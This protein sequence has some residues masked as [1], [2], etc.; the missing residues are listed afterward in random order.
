MADHARDAR[1][2]AFVV[3]YGQGVRGTKPKGRLRVKQT[4]DKVIVDTGVLRIVIP[5]RTGQVIESVSLDANRD[6]KFDASEQ[7]A[8]GGAQGGP[9]L[10]DDTGKRYTALLDTAPEVTVEE[11]GPV[12]A[13]VRIESWYVAPKDKGGQRLCK[14]I[15]RLR[16]YQGLARVDLSHGWLMTARTAEV[17]FSDIGFSL[18]VP[19]ARH[20]VLAGDPDRELYR[21]TI[22]ADRL[23][24]LLQDRWNHFGVHIN[25]N[26]YTFADPKRRSLKRI[27]MADE[28]YKSEGWGALRSPRGVVAV[29]CEDFW[30]NYPKEISA[31]ASRLTFHVWPG[32]GVDHEREPRHDEVIN[33]YWLHESR[34]LNFLIAPEVSCL[35]VQNWHTSKYFMHFAKRADAMGLMKTHEVKLSFFPPDTPSESLRP[36][37]RA[38]RRPNVVCADPA[39]MVDSGVFGP[40][41][42]RDPKRYP[43]AERALD[44][45]L[46]CD[47]RWEKMNRAW[48]MFIFGGGHSR[49]ERGQQRFGIYR[50]WRN[51]HHGNP[52]TPW[53]L[54]FRSGDLFFFRRALRNTRKVIDLGMCHYVRKEPSREDFSGWQTKTVG[55]CTTT[56]GWSRGTRA[57]APATTTSTGEAGVRE[58]H[59]H[60]LRPY[61]GGEVPHGNAARGVG[62]RTERGPPARGHDHAALLHVS[63]RD[64]EQVVPG[65]REGDGL[66]PVQERRVGPPGAA[67]PAE[68][69]AEAGACRAPSRLSRHLRELVH[70]RAVLQLAEREGGAD[71][72]IRL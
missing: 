65:L 25:Y 50:V 63:V 39:A 3:E 41:A 35:P 19:E 1:S 58:L 10:A 9:Y 68:G 59:R 47:D 66:Q 62:T 67:V 70:L 40:I 29:G 20:V 61:S 16:A 15:T 22:S 12:R 55:G 72:S 30:Q 64:R 46:R 45:A 4:D 32:H 60:A 28:G 48:G 17:R 27:R 42:V 71:A 49:F 11:A 34:L 5:T 52:R 44:L 57:D 2:S 13:V 24:Y 8:V 54:F 6:G 43:E 38:L 14:H 7:V 31:D 23:R 56:R 69:V 36:R 26:T 37:M 21:D 18:D 51:M 33:L 53:L